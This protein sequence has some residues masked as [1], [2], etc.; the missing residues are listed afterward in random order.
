LR[1]T[2]PPRILNSRQRLLRGFAPINSETLLFVAVPIVGFIAGFVNT[3]AGS[4]SLV[5]LPVLI[6]LGLPANVA[7]GT[8][9]V[10]ILVQNIVAVATFRSRGALNIGESPRLV[11]PAIFGAIV[12]AALA[13]DLDEALLNRTIGILMIVMLA[14][15]LLRPR[16]WLQAHAGGTAIHYGW[17]IPLY[18]GIG[19][20]CGFIQAGAGVFLIAALVLGSGYDLVR[21][22]A[23]K[24]LIVLIVTVAALAVFV[25]NG[26]VRW[27]IGLLL[28]TGNAAG[29]WVGANMAVSRGAGFV[30]WVLVVI[31]ALSAA[32]LFSDYRI[33]S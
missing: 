29:A 6:L 2:Y 30:R 23:M 17:Q 15:I 27:G 4:G 14:I 26:Q 24:N 5:T 10:G 31:I 32:A 28:A 18:F 7:N 12:G 8:N 20:Y 21:G 22:N 25:I 9:R 11:V 16:R 1:T 19:A 33:V 3:L 13:V